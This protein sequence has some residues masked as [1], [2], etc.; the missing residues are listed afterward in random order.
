MIAL[1]LSRARARRRCCRR[2]AACTNWRFTPALNAGQLVRPLLP[3]RAAGHGAEAQWRPYAQRA[4]RIS[5]LTRD[6]SEIVEAETPLRQLL[7][8]G[9]V[10]FHACGSDRRGARRNRR[11]AT[12]KALTAQLC[13][14][15]ISVVF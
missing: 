1:I 12:G 10:A 14:T 7:H 13:T 2:I 15:N 11:K 8:A 3:L 6:I 5:A 9:P 4:L